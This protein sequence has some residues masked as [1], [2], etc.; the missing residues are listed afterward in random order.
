M[1]PM[2]ARAEVTLPSDTQILI[3][4]EFDA[5]AR[6]V[7]RAWTEPE[8]VRRWWHARRGEMTVAEID[9]RVGGGWRYAMIA[10]GGFEVAFHGEYR[11][12]VP[13][14]RIVSTEIYE[15]AP[16]AQ[17]LS[18]VTFSESDGRT[19]LELLVEHTCPEHR[20]MHLEAGM[21]D[22]LQDALELLDEAAG[23]L[24]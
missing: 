23:S 5:P 13:G 22:G 2:T 12:I 11:E 14:R 19:R 20:D 21:E 9:L 24:R 16:E 8:L 6:L 3:S 15:G 1:N 18:T 4:R 7:Y 17:A 10:K